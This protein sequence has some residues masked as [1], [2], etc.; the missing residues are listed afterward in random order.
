VFNVDFVSIAGSR[1]SLVREIET[2]LASNTARNDP[3]R[4]TE[5]GRRVVQLL[6]SVRAQVIR[7][8]TPI[9]PLNP[10]NQVDVETRARIVF[11]S[12][13]LRHSP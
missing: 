3:K 11:A 7:K 4:D 6:V 10:G 2:K 5:N 9:N 8:L 1:D 13:G 12:M